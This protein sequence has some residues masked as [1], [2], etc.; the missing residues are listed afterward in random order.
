MR[1]ALIMAG[2]TGGHVFPG[3]AVA[4]ALRSQGINV[5]W[6]GTHNGL[7]ARVVPEAGFPVEWITIQG[8]RRGSLKDMVLLPGRLAVALWQAFRIFR[9]HRPALALALGGFVAGPGGVVAWLTRTPLV[10]HE[11][12]AYAGLTN[13]WLALIADRVLC[14]FPDAF[15]SLPGATHIGNPVRSEI[16][17]V[18]KPDVRLAG[19]E[20][21][22]RVL[23]VGG[24]Q[25]AQI[26]NEVVPEAVALLDPS[27]RPLI[28]HQSGP[29]GLQQTET[30]YRSHGITAAVVPFIADMAAEY[31]WADVVICRAGAM[32][33]AELCAVGTTAILVPFP[34][35]T[36]D[37]Q[38]ANARF[39]TDREAAIC[40]TQAEF[41]ASH[42]ADLLSGLATQPEVAALMA[43]RSRACAMPDATDRIVAACLEVARA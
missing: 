32:T 4:R 39:L 31:T 1:T 29:A 10:V 18:P 13:R 5:V 9:R 41:S 25:G 38:T 40:V 22:L 2:G 7:E 23:V 37:H 15:G 30:R 16:L 36:D 43:E 12:N 24:S 34:F 21:P 33:I 27:V 20:P 8:L 14:G 28:H 19:R 3:L 11:Q 17:A 42:V 6:V 26:L 35:A